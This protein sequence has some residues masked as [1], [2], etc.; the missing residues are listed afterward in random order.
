MFPKGNSF[1]HRLL[2]GG[3]LDG[4]SALCVEIPSP[5]W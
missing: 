2:D 3:V 4:A 5:L 1:Q